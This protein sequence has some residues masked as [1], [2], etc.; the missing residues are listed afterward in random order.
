MQKALLTLMSFLTAEKANEKNERR[1][2]ETRT[3]IK[4]ERN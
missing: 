2:K 4:N 3:N 1:K